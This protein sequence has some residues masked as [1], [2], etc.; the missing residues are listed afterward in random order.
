VRGTD[1]IELSFTTPSP[2]L[3]AFLAAAHTQAYMEANDEA[4]RETDAVAEAFLARQ[5]DDA[6]AQVERAD[7]ALAAFAAEYPTVATN[8]EQKVVGARITELS[9]L[10]TQAEADRTTLESRAEFVTD[11]SNDRLAYFL[12][13]P[14]VEKLRLAL[15]DARSAGCAEDAPRTEP[16][17]DARADRSGGGARVLRRAGPDVEAVRS[18]YDAAPREERLREAAAHE[19][20]GIGSAPSA[21]RSAERRRPARSLACSDAWRGELR[22]GSA[23]RARHRAGEVLHQPE[24]AEDPAQPGARRLQRRRDRDRGRLRA[25]VRHQ[26][27][28][29]EVQTL[30]QLPTLAAIE[31]RSPGRLPVLPTAR[32]PGAGG[33]RSQRYEPWSWVVGPSSM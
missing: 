9:S 5:L 25:R 19:Q 27:R 15:L 1:L 32:L 17:P 30:L 6:R 20:T 26:P 3:S 7:A 31:P 14:G 29:D 16:S 4:R 8:Q 11:P 21:L 2:D 28:S 18:Q 13:H 24:P 22:A 10:L 23:Q 33:D 12:Q